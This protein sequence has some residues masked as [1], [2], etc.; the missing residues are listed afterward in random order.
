MLRLDRTV[1]ECL[2]RIRTAR[3][4]R[5]VKFL[6]VGSNVGMHTFTMAPH[7]DAVLSVEAMP[8]NFAALKDAS[9]LNKRHKKKK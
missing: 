8:H 9:C 5:S 2:A 7:V 3:P 4:G 6:V 1:S